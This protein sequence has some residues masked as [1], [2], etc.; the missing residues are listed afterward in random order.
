MQWRKA[1]EASPPAQNPSAHSDDTTRGGSGGAKRD[2]PA[3]APPAPAPARARVAPPP[4]LA[5]PI[6]P[7]APPGAPSPAPRPH[8]APPHARAAALDSYSRHN[9]L[10]V[11]IAATRARLAHHLARLGEDEARMREAGDAVAAH[12]RHAAA[13]VA[14]LE[15]M[16][17]RRV[18]EVWGFVASLAAPPGAAPPAPPAA[19]PAAAPQQAVWRPPPPPPAAAWQSPPAP[20]AW[21]VPPRAA[22]PSPYGF[23]LRLPAP[24]P[25][26]LAHAHTAAAAAP[27]RYGSHQQHYAPPPPPPPPQQQQ[28]A[29]P[30]WAPPAAPPAAPP[31]PPPPA[32]RADSWAGGDPNWSL[33]VVEL[34]G[35]LA[36]LE[37][38]A[39]LP[40]GGADGDGDGDALRAWAR[41]VGAP[42]A[43]PLAAERLPAAASPP[44]PPPPPAPPRAARSPLYGEH[45]MPAPAHRPPAPAPGARG[46]GAGWLAQQSL[47][48]PPLREAAH[49]RQ[50]FSPPADAALAPWP[51][52]PFDGADGAAAAD[53][54]LQD[55][56]LPAPAAP[57]A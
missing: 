11:A 37:G 48:A 33:P 54:F 56:F 43:P 41:A 14:E 7:G 28:P 17:D 44:A 46:A 20:G 27:P 10:Q 3:S 32:A 18:A 51:L 39:S 1:Q 40:A 36:S 9:S 29:V 5:S 30:Q 34:P 53:F 49:E 57:L 8:S 47:L 35:A 16:E 31:P 22:P 4:P 38:A 42:G 23:V 55:T 45:S 6:A 13:A 2:A 21:A 15:R 52:S 25:H 24:L 19:A 12:R 26:Q 50:P